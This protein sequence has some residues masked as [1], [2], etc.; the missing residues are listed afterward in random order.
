M[1]DHRVRTLRRYYIVFSIMLNMFGFALI[2]VILGNGEKVQ[3]L[4][5]IAESDANVASIIAVTGIVANLGLA[6]AL[7][8]VGLERRR[9]DA[10]FV[11]DQRPPFTGV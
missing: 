2:F 11:R 3:N 8:K 10:A 4:L 1:R 6:Y 9:R 7:W 5:Y